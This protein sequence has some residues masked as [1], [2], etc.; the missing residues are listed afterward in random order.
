MGVYQRKRTGI[1]HTAQETHKKSKLLCRTIDGPEG[2]SRWLEK[3]K[4]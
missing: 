3:V 1:G 4:K 2:E